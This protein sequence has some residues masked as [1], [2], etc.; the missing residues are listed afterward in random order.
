MNDAHAHNTGFASGR[1]IRQENGRLC[2]A[3]ARELCVRHLTDAVFS[4]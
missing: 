4:G 3:G 2:L 1:V